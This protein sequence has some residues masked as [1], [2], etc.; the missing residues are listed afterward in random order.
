MTS[1]GDAPGG[2]PRDHGYSAEGI[3]TLLD[4]FVLGDPDE[5]LRLRL[6]LADLQQSAFGV[7]LFVAILP[8]FLPV[9]G[10]AGGISGPLVTLIGVQMLI[11][12]R[13]PWLPRFIG[14]R[15]PRRRTMQRFVG[16]IAPWLR[17][18]DRLLK[19][20]LPALVDTLPA[21]A[22]SG[23][24]LIVLGI[25]LS[26]PIPFTNYAFGAM[27]LLFALALL[28]RDGG[29]MLLSWLG[30]IAVALSLGLASDQ[31]VDLGREWMQKLR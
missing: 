19:P 15:G 20:R 12:L 13:K 17:R 26:L 7:F 6:I 25:L 2:E 29:L 14:E 27:L 16:R 28:E 31:V 1:P 22:F 9:P 21:R 10:L 24:L 30:S 5:H 8:A 23:L 3:R 4:T 11:G 18:L